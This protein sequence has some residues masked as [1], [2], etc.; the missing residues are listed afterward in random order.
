MIEDPSSPTG[1]SE[2][3]LVVMD[4]DSLT[5]KPTLVLQPS[6]SYTPGNYN[7]ILVGTLPNGVTTSEPFSVS[8]LDC[9]V[10][11]MYWVEGTSISDL[12]NI[13]Y[14]DPQ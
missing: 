8:V 13:W 14:D 4:I 1:Y 12:T 5:G 3:D 11:N 6:L 10:D 9:V 2:T 7:L